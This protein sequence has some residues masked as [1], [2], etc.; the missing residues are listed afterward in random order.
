MDQKTTGY[1]YG[2]RCQE[3]NSEKNTTIEIV[4]TKA[5]EKYD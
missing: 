3:S 4:G 1:I 5:I 2:H